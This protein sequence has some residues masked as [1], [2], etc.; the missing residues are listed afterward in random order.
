MLREYIG[1]E[2]FKSGLKAYFQKHAYQNTTRHDLW[3]ALSSASNKP[4]SKLMHS[5]LEQSGMP[6]LSVSQEAKQIELSQKRLLLDESKN[7]NQVWQIP[8]LSNR[9]LSTDILSGKSTTLTLDNDSIILFNE[10]ASGHFVVDYN[11]ETGRKQR[12]SNVQKRLISTSGRISAL[13]D[14]ILLARGGEETLTSGLK[15]I[16]DCQDEPREN[17][18][19][20]MGSILNHAKVLTEGNTNTEN[21]LKKLA[22]NLAV[23]NIKNLVGILKTRTTPT[24]HSYDEQCWCLW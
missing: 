11:T 3:Q 19:S 18:W 7:D 23:K 2:A 9:Q 8:L 5:W 4:L 12:A 15:L 16:S 17:V 20:L 13:N 14:I 22:Y 6:I 21:Q 24:Q 1:E 10:N